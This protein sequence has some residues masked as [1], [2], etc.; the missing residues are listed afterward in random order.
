MKKGSPSEETTR[1]ERNQTMFQRILVPLDGSK[2]AE[3]AIPVAARL[4]RASGGSL[5]FVRV[6]VPPVKFGTYTPRHSIALKP[7]AFKARMEAAEAYLINT[8]AAY[9][10]D[11]GNLEDIEMDIV[12]GAASPSIFSTAQWANVDLI[13]LFSH[14][15]TGLKRWV[16]GSI[17]HESVR[18]SPVPV[19]VLNE[20]CLMLPEPSEDPRL[21]RVLVALDGSSRAETAIEPAAHLVS[22]LAA[23]GELHLFSVLDMPS[24]GG[25]FRRPLPFDTMIREEARQEAE[26]YLKGVTERF[27]ESLA[28]FNITI[29][30]SVVVSTTGVAET[31]LKQATH[32]QE[33][34][35]SDDFAL[36]ALATHGRHGLSHLIMGSVTE[37]MLST[38]KLPLLIVRPYHSEASAQ[39]EA[40][41]DENI[42]IEV[43]ETIEVQQ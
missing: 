25:K 1:L 13:V 40:Q 34:Q 14:Q 35:K 17:A 42:I 3:R 2:Y 22:L 41:D 7:G 16:F 20:D 38:T 24:E 39:P 43:T 8:V 28:A 5:V 27:R 9:A 15:E 6:V 11:L 36:I 29:T 37:H 18:H 31:I 32:A 12:A 26:A 33:A 30:S 23:Q 19:L 21:L 10:D 4:A